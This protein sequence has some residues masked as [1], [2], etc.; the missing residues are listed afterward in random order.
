MY[1]LLLP[2]IILTTY[3]LLSFSTNSQSVPTGDGFIKEF[4]VLGPF[5]V[6]EDDSLRGNEEIQFQA[7]NSEL[8][9]PELDGEKKDGELLVI[10]GNEY[11][12]QSIQTEDGLVN[13]D[14]FYNQP[15][16]VYSYVFTEIESKTD[17]KA[18]L[19]IGSDDGI[20]VWLNGKKVFE[21]WE[22]RP[23]NFNEDLISVDLK[24]GKNKLL[25][26]VQDMEFDWSMS[27]Q[28]LNHES[29]PK[30]IVDAAR[31][32]HIDQ[33]ALLVD[34]GADVNA[35]VGP[36]ISPLHVA[37]IKG[38]QEII[39]LLNEMG[40][41]DTP[42]PK[43]E[44]IVDF[45][46]DDYTKEKSSAMSILVS[47]DGNVLFKKAYGYANMLDDLMANPQTT[48][49]IGSITKQFTSTAIL[50]LVEEGKLKLD[51]PLQRFI[52]DFPKGDVVT[53]HHLLTHISGIHSFTNDI[54]FLDRVK[55]PIIWADL[56]GEI[57][58]SPYDF[59]PG[60][61]WSYNNSGY[62]ILG[63]LV[64]EVS[65]TSFEG[66]LKREIFEPLGMLNTGVY[67][68]S[69]NYMDEAIGYSWENQEIALA[70][71]WDMTWAGG[72][73]NMYSTVEDLNKWNEALF[74]GKVLG[75]DMM[76]EAM[77]PVKLNNGEEATAF[78][79][80]YGYGWAFSEYRD[81][82]VIGHSGGLH[83]FSTNLLRFPE[84][85]ATICVLTNAMPARYIDPSAMSFELADLFFMDELAVQSS[86]S[87][88]VVVNKD[89]FSDYI[90]HYEYPGGGIFTV[91]IEGEELFGAFPG[92]PRIK[93]FP[94]K[95]QIFYLKDIN[96][97][98]TFFRDSNGQT[99][100]LEHQQSGQTIRAKKVEI[101]VPVEIDKSVYEDFVGTYNLGFASMEIT[102][103]DD[104]LFAQVEGQP[105]LEIFPRASEVYFFKAVIA[106]ITFKRDENGNVIELLL[107]Q[108]GMKMTGKK[109][110]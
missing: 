61:L 81:Q 18:L 66:Y 62:F 58:E 101:E 33:V 75:K 98:L 31:L 1:K 83:G 69:V 5:E 68:N 72:A 96:A 104:H 88:N 11:F 71:D 80:T 49:R 89:V 87:E 93:L 19:G 46:A 64:E 27:C 25:F 90:G 50:K 91:S 59:E 36:G 21:L 24:A 108:A 102:T 16:F 70:L 55:D 103:D 42:M 73:G 35:S 4:M 29:F 52:P 32:G 110:E 79:S 63:Y 57:K 97:T 51:D 6:F 56:I 38:R 9:S 17:R 41:L 65:G 84:L 54:K 48:F 76:L 78:G 40:A 94:Q 47:E 22:G 37:K 23:H 14:K 82:K 45:I 67:D 77:T 20:K 2:S 74:S 7:F 105:K 107:D 53:I 15:D 44:E 8:L 12:W 86:F 85:D 10:E 99:T 26:K 43:L 95:E 3:L 92:N 30:L 109:E 34:H 13:L 60:E 28:I 100:H 39:K 106:S